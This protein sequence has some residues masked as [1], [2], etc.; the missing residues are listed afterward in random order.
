MSLTICRIGTEESAS[1]TNLKPGVEYTI[2]IV[3]IVGP[4]N[5]KSASSIQK[6]SYTSKFSLYYFEL[7]S[8]Q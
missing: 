7:A 6:Q 2:T 1:F 8:Q 4:D 5:I 3:T